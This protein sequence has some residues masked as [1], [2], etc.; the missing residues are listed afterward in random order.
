[1]LAK[2]P[3]QVAILP[4]KVPYGASGTA[5]VRKMGTGLSAQSVVQAAY[6]FESSTRTV[7]STELPKGRYDYIA[8][9]PSGN[10]EALQHEAKR[11]F[12]VIARRETRETNVLRL[13]VKRANAERIRPSATQGGSSQ[14]R[15]GKFSCRNQPISCLTSFLENY[16]ETPVVDQTGMTDRFDIDLTWDQ[17]D[18]RQRNP[19]ALNQALLDQLGLQLAPSREPIEMLV[20]EKVKN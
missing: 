14:S 1:M 6:E 2:L 20:I 17:P 19:E 4:S 9:L 16:L 5:G 18:W 11:K 10:A 12:G 8:S 13:G 3:R 15:N 7:V